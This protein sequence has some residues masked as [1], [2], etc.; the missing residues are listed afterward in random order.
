VFL[1]PLLL[2]F[3]FSFASAIL[4]SYRALYAFSS[5][6]FFLFSCINEI[7]VTVNEFYLLIFHTCSSIAAMY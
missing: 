1:N 2:F 6:K 5:K 7:F 3:S 4:A